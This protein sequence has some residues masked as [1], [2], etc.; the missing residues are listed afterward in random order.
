MEDIKDAE[1]V[2]EDV[3]IQNLGKYYDLK[4]QSDWLLLAFPIRILRRIT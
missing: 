3:G 2:W 1:K 4:V